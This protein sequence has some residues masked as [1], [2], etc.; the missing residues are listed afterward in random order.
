MGLKGNNNIKH[1]IKII[2]IADSTDFLLS[3]IQ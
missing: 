3:S 1:L 2:E